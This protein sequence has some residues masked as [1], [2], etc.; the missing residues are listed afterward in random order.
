M[1]ERD[2]RAPSKILGHEEHAPEASACQERAAAGRA[3]TRIRERQP[4]PR[5]TSKRA[6]AASSPRRRPRSAGFS[7]EKEFGRSP[8][9]ALLRGIG[10]FGT[11]WVSCNK[12]DLDHPEIRGDLPRKK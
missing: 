1:R 11:R 2:I 5:R 6:R 7:P 12:G 4:G 8:L 9:G 3:D 10:F